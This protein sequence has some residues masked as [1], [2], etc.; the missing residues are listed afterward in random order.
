VGKTELVRAL[1]EFMFGSE[2]TMIRLDMSEFMERHAVARL[3][4]APP[5]YVG[6]DEGGQLTEAVRRKPYCVI[7]LD[8]LEKAHPD[9][10]NI[11]LQI[12]DD[13]HLTDAKGRRVDFRNSIVV[14]TSNIG[15][16]LIK[17]D[18]TLG[19]ATHSDEEKKRQ[20]DYDKMKDKVLGELKKTFR[21]EFLNRIDGVVV[22]H[23]LTKEQ[24]RRIVDLMLGL[25]VK[26]LGE[27]NIELEVTDA[28]KDYLGERGY[29]PTFG[30]RPLRRVIQSEVE[31]KLSEALLRGEFRSGDILKVD[32][33]G[34]QI[35]IRS[36]SGALAGGGID[37]LLKG[38]DMHSLGEG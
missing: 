7:L 8:E 21:P 31:D 19:F 12:F 2:D 9:V 4:G 24:I 30:A 15:A 32:Y 29:D 22:F 5:G 14:M 3:V 1:A 17:R 36:A 20:F 18:M 25:V 10:F 35:M 34:E 23:S 37:N 33:D 27:K 6:Y 38:S 16:E 11:L 26:S 13:G 28:A